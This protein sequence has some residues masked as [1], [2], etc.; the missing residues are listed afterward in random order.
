MI[1]SNGSLSHEN[2]DLLLLECG[3]LEWALIGIGALINKKTHS[4]GG[5]YSKGALIGRRALNRIITVVTIQLCLQKI[6]IFFRQQ[7]SDGT[8]NIL[9]ITSFSQEMA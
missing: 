4:K 5:S 1:S 9:N 6:G 8:N 7:T 2:K 3:L